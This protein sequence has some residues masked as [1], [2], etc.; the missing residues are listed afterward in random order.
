MK[1]EKILKYIKVVITIAIPCLFIWF[2]I[3]NPFI[4]F[5][6][7]EKTLEDA[8]K[9]YYQLN[10]DK[11]P[12]GKRL[13][14]VTMKTLFDK[15]YITKDFYIPYTNKPCS[16]SNS[17]VKVKQTDSGDYKYYT[18]LECGVFK[19]KV[20]SSGPTIT[21]NG[22]SEITIN[23]GEEYKEL[24]VKSLKDNTD[25]K[26]DVSNVTIDSSNVDTSKTGT[27]EVTYTAF[28]SLK[29][30]TTVKR[31]VNVVQKLNK[32]VQ[33]ATGESRIYKGQYVD[34]Y[35]YFS[36][37]LFRIIGLD[38]NN[39]KIVSANDIS[40]INYSAIDK[41]LDYFLEH[42]DT[43]AKKI[44]VKN[45]YCYGTI[46]KEE[47]N[48]DVTCIS[49]TKKRYAY[50]LSNKELNES[51]DEREQ[52]Y[53]F[54][55]T[56]SWTAARSNEPCQDVPD[57]DSDGN[58]STAWATKS[59]FAPIA[60]N[61]Q[62]LSL[63]K[64]YNLGIRPVLTLNGDSLVKAGDGT[65]EN[66]YFLGEIKRG[67]VDEYL[68]SRLSGEYL[69]YSGFLWRIMEVTN[70]QYVKVISEEPISEEL[71]SYNTEDDI[72]IYNPSQKGNIG[73]EINK[74]ATDTINEQYFVTWKVNVPIYDKTAKF[75]E[76]KS[77]KTYKV[78]FA[79]PNMYEMFTTVQSKYG[80]GYWL[81]NSSNEEYRK[82]AVSNSGIVYYG[83]L[84]NLFETYIRPVGYL[85][86]SIKI[87]S[88]SG[89]KNDPYKIS[90]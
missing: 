8:A 62:Y 55:V 20:D 85:D 4:G 14:T 65:L 11:L 58:A 12:T 88:G 34:N 51:R 77:T 41:W 86:K 18:Y 45:N 72:K 68:N 31:V 61:S 59:D 7:N 26:M 15:E 29:N 6:K 37:M 54:P 71:I 3:I 2:L 53:L 57:E 83:K 76:K 42:V 82:Y 56:M 44:L 64:D 19:S 35:I 66:P 48:T 84:G 81:I 46:G 70:D 39:V 5:K 49:K 43:N 50:I 23:R 25:G 75:D 17:W 79:A 16:V 1:K 13:A 67:K 63:D 69:T 74:K 33:D 10:D 90:K 38:G 21:L 60:P 36:G 27:Y 32:T 87:V 40:S 9:K 47:I 30:K 24:G 52:S 89:T 80:Y 78:K 28:D 22:D 73:Y